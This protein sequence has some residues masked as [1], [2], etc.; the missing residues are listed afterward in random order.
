M[1]VNLKTIPLVLLGLLSLSACGESEP[2]Q[3]EHNQEEHN[4]NPPTGRVYENDSDAKLCIIERQ[5]YD[6]LNSASVSLNETSELEMVVGLFLL[7]YAGRGPLL[8]QSCSVELDD[9]TLIVESRIAFGPDTPSQ[10]DSAV[11]DERFMACDIPALTAGTYQVIHG[12][13]TYTVTIPS[14]GNLDCGASLFNSFYLL[15]E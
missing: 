5:D 10:G 8:E 15:D 1:K 7:S 3:E 2:H 13:S 14:E 6:S 4:Q 12:D 11:N 9:D